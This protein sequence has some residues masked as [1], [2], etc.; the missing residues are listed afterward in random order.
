MFKMKLITNCSAALLV[1]LMISCG[2]SK[3]GNGMIE[4][5][6]NPPFQALESYIQPWVAGVKEGGS[7]K[8]VAL[9]LS[10]SENVEVNFLKMYFGKQVKNI[11]EYGTN[12]EMILVSFKDGNDRP[13][14]VMSDDPIDETANKPSDRFNFNLED[15]EVVI[16]YQVQTE[17][18]YYKLSSIQVKELLAY[19]ASKPTD[20]QRP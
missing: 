17:V 18:R 2:S 20:E 8:D 5:D 12:P 6:K 9:K 1:V 3:N 10:Y 16:S 13:D 4:F 15:D 7:G 14:T 19:P 11:P